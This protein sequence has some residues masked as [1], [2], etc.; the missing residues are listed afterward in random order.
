MRV[1]RASEARMRLD[2][3]LARCRAHG[4]HLFVP[5]LLRVTGVAMLEQARLRLPDVA[6]AYEADGHRH[7]QM[8]I[9]TAN[10]GA[11]MWALRGALDLADHLIERGRTAHAST[12]VAGVARHFDPHSRAHDALLR[13]QNFVRC[14]T[15][16]CRRPA[17]VR[18]DA[19]DAGRGSRVR[20]FLAAARLRDRAC[21]C[22]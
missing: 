13:V 12:L 4:E 5:E 21:R 16:R 9:Q 11:A 18:H 22:A 14:G 17:R 10:A 19:A 15:R 8:A 7:L 20:A 2:A 3:T 6:L 1:G